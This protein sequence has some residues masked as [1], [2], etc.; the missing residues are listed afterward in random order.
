MF[1]GGKEDD[2]G[3]IYSTVRTGVHCVQSPLFL[4]KTVQFLNHSTRAAR[5]YWHLRQE[6]GKYRDSRGSTRAA[7]TIRTPS[8]RRERERKRID[9]QMEYFLA[10]R[11]FVKY[12]LC[13]MKLL[14][15]NLKISL[16][17]ISR[18]TT[19]ELKG[20]EKK[21]YLTRNRRFCTL[22]HNYKAI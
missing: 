2:E 1:A 10:A 7:A 21:S 22:I 3:H 12:L 13:W 18:K 8:M 16:L 5:A 20:E 11:K 14:F 17:E 4:K 15:S 6:N 9:R 19:L